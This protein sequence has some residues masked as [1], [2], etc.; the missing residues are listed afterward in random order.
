MAYLAKFGS[1]VSKTV[2]THHAGK[3]SPRCPSPWTNHPKTFTKC[4]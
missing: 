2:S 3:C 1:C 4:N